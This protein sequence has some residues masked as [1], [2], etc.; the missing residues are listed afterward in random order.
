L[1]IILSVCVCVHFW[2]NGVPAS[3]SIIVCVHFWGN[4]VPAS[5]SIIVCVHFW[6]NG[7]KEPGVSQ[8]GDFRAVSRRPYMARCYMAL[9]STFR[10]QKRNPWHL[11]NIVA[12][13]VHESGLHF[14]QHISKYWKHSSTGDDIM[15]TNA[16]CHES[17][18]KQKAV[19]IICRSKESGCRGCRF[20]PP[21]P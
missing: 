18:Q 10:S 6:G 7:I 19:P 1:S 3:L 21:F 12:H 17:L 5:L 8:N 2:G 13:E 15:V 20:R 11:Q 4:G 16:K 9:R 14:D